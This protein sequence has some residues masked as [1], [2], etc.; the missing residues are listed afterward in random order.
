M[1]KGCKKN[2]SFYSKENKKVIGKFKDDMCGDPI[3]EFIGLRPKLYSILY[4]INLI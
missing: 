3:V 2:S 1:D 4:K